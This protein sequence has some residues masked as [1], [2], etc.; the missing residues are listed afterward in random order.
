MSRWT[1]FWVTAVLVTLLAGLG[2]VPATAA[3]NQ[4]KDEKRGLTFEVYK[5]KADEFRWRLKAG[6]GAIIAVSGEGYK[7]KADC[8]HGIE[9]IKEGAAK[10]KVEDT[11]K[12]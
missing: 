2:N 10:A 1:C 6:N 4:A 7:A 12:K 5:D 3:R 9:L 8:E 11:T